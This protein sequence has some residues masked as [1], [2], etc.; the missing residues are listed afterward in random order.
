MPCEFR[1]SVVFGFVR[2]VQATP[3]QFVNKL[4]ALPIRRGPM[5]GFESD[6]LS[7]L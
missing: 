2:I 7:V 4:F 1:L 3:V 5:H 6:S